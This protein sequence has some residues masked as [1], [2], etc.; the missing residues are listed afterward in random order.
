MHSSYGRATVGGASLTASTRPTEFAGKE[1]PGFFKTSLQRFHPLPIQDD[2]AQRHSGAI[3][4]FSPAP[5]YARLDHQCLP[6]ADINSGCRT[7]VSWLERNERVF[8]TYPQV[9]R[10][11]PA[12]SIEDA[13]QR[14]SRAIE[15]GDGPGLLIGG[16]GTGKS[17]LLQVLAAQY[18]ERFDVV[19]LACARLCTRRALLQ[20][21]LFELGLP[22]THARRRRVAAELARPLALG[23]AVPDRP[24]AAGRRGPGVA[25][26]HAGRA[27]RD[28]EPGAWRRAAR[29]AGAGRLVGLEEAFATGAGIVQP[30]TVGTVLLGAA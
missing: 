24:A 1:L 7:C 12:A 21:I 19:L 4:A 23:R 2:S 3:R 18:H 15:R 9:A 14:L 28:D 22:Y 5:L 10:Y 27:A 20:A 6:H 17:L 13:R 11:F 30:A 25:D 29:A 8:A 26:R 16:A